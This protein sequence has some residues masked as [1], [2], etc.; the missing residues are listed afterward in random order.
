MRAICICL[1]EYPEAIKKAQAHFASAGLEDVEF[2][3][4]IN[5]PVAGLAT[6]HVYE[7]DNPGSGFRMGAK[8][9]GIWLSHW[10]TW[11]MLTRLP[12]DKFLILETDAQ[13][14]PDWKERFGRAMADVPNDFDFL[15]VGHCCIEGFPRTLVAGEVYESKHAQCT[16]AYVLSRKAI[17]F[18]LRTL[19]K[20]W[21][22][23]DIQLQLECFPHLRTFAVVPRI[24]DQ[25]D[26]VLSP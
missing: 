18:L 24:V 22:P 13:F 4:G 25:F 6:W 21:S 11:N 17:P 2:F 23:I 8:P 15:H 7:R 10:M 16:H 5:A 26:T 9:T 20:I 14:R 12:D 3:W 1:P 19:R